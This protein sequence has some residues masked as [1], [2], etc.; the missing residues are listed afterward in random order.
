MQFF[1]ISDVGMERSLNEDNFSVDTA[2]G[3]LVALVCDGM[4]GA[5]AGEVASRLACKRFI[6]KIIPRLREIKESVTDEAELMI[7]TD[8]AVYEACEEANSEVYLASKNDERLSGMGTTL[9]GCMIDGD[10]LWTFNV[11]DSRV[12]HITRDKAE[13]LTVDHSFVQALVDDGKITP[14]EAQNHP[15]R[16]VILRALGVQSKVE[17]DVSH[18]NTD[19][20]YYLVCS[21][22]MSNYFD[23]K[24][25]I[26]IT[27]SDKSI[28]EKAEDL[29]AFANSKGGSDNITVVL[30]DTE[31]QTDGG[32]DEQ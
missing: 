26:R 5:N 24:E 13:Q 30:I 8:R 11:G 1:G 2:D 25:F 14:E 19:G 20:G 31:K 22:G 4:G 29:V 15:N 9:T 18:Y 6:G 17:C 28:S 3:I 12:Y 32:N 23:E 16:N 27:S 7:K 10:M 21:D